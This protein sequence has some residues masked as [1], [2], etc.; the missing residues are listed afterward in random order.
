MTMFSPDHT[1][2]PWIDTRLNEEEMNF[3]RDAIENSTK[4]N[5]NKELAGNIYKSELIE[6]KDNWFYETTLK[7]LSEKMF[8]RNHGNYYVEYIENKKSLPKFEMNKFWV[9]Y[10]KQHEFNPFHA[11]SGFYSFV[12]FMKIPTNWKE[13]HA[14]PIS[15]HSNS[16]Y[17]SDFAFVH[18]EKNTEY[19]NSTNFPLSPE[20]EG[21][22]LF[23]PSW[24]KHMVYP[25]YGTEEERVTISGN[26]VLND[27]NKPEIPVTAYEQKENMLKIMKNGVQQMEEELKQM[28]K[29][30]ENV[31]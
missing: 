10:M 3:L 28:K 23:F 30:R 25:F 27:S 17:A 31:G 26:I 21:R 22:M 11:H 19:C 4:E 13:Q 24:L 9:N 12:I 1:L 5:M 20:D 2:K 29:E 14:L 6:D 7:P 15:A 18:S 16:P 8:C